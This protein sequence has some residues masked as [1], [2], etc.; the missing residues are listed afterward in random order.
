M[1]HMARRNLIL[2]VAALL[3]LTGCHSKGSEGVDSKSTSEAAPPTQSGPWI[4]AIPNPVPIP[5]G[6]DQGTTT[7]SWDTVDGSDAQVFLRV[8]G[9]PDKIFSGGSRNQQD[10]NWIMKGKDY[11]FILFAGKEHQKELARVTI[12]AAP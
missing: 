11:D 12:R 8:A 4:K 3:A 10:A 2:G 6:S 9:K 1:I 7:I 5:A